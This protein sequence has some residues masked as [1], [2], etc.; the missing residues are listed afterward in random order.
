MTDFDSLPQLLAELAGACGLA[1]ALK[2]AE[3]YGGTR[4]HVPK[5]VNPAHP[6]FRALGPEAAAWLVENYGGDRVDVP[7]GPL[8]NDRQRRT[9]IRRLIE[10]NA[11]ERDIARAVGI[12]DRTVRRHRAAI[13]ERRNSDQYDLLD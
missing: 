12:T 2:L 1:A 10:E 8:A 7:L 3:A 9:R 4:L 6:L 5:R 11:S 13:R